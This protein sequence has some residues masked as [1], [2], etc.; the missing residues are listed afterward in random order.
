MRVLPPSLITQERRSDLDVLQRLFGAPKPIIAACTLLALPGRPRHDSHGGI[1]AIVED[2]LRDVRAL[3][4]AEV[5]ALIFVN[6]KD[7]PYSKS[8]APEVIAAAAAVIGRIRSEI[9]LPFGVDIFCDARASLAVAR[10]TGATFARGVF[11]GVYDTDMGLVERD[12]GELAAYRRS[13]GADDVAV[14]GYITA[15]YGQSISN[16]PLAERA[17]CA[18]FLGL[19]ALLVTALHSG[20]PLNLE[21]LRVVKQAAGDV[22]VIA[23]NGVTSTTAEQMLAIA[24]GAL[25]GSDLREGGSIWQ[26]VD[27]MRVRRLV[28]VVGAIRAKNTSSA[29]GK[30]GPTT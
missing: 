9:R 2:V 6:E 5:D 1:D 21:D 4:Q 22:P 16:R 11:S 26:P 24:D 30:S 17:A 13:I 18:A 23:A 20:M 8:A 15:E 10:A 14:F 19:D 29:H 3:Q 27:P 28:E 7:F 25:V 12:W